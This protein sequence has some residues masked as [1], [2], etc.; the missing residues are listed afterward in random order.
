[1]RKALMLASAGLISARGV[2]INLSDGLFNSG[3]L[4]A[5]DNLVINA[6]SITNLLGQLQGNNVD[7]RASGG[8][9]SI[10]GDIAAR[11][12]LTMK[13]R[14]DMVFVGGGI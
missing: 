10:L 12:N 1:M 11:Q 13:A 8:I 14:G 6:G 2:N 7:L 9:T 4:A 5:R 3:T